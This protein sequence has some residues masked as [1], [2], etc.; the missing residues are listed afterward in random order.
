MARLAKGID[1]QRI[2]A[3]RLVADSGAR[4]FV[5]AFRRTLEKGY[6]LDDLQIA[7][8]KRMQ[9]FFDAASQMTVDQID[10]RYRRRADPKDIVD[11][12]QV[13]HYG[14]DDGFRIHGIYTD[15]YFEVIRIDPN[16]K[17]HGA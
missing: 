14:R 8:L 15:G 12:Q 4:P 11:G 1:G 13:Q 9:A 2:A 7:D 10:A 5:I 3:K 17:V 6:K 16:H